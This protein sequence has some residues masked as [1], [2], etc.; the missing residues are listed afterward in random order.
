MIANPPFSLKEWGARFGR[1]TGPGRVRSPARELRRLRL[2]SAHGRVDGRAHR[3]DG[4]CCRKGAV[5]KSAEGR[6]RQALLEED[7]IEA[8]IGLAPNVFYGTGLAPRRGDPPPLSRPSARRRSGDRRL[9]PLPQGRAQNFLELEHAGRSSAWA[10]AFEDVETAPRSSVSTR[11]SPRTG[12]STSPAT[13]C[14]RSATRSAARR[15]SPPSQALAEA[16]RRGPAARGADRG[17]LGLLSKAAKHLSQQELESY[18]RGQPAPRADRRWRLQAVRLPAALLQAAVGRGTRS[19]APRSTRPAT[20]PMRGR[21]PTTASPSPT[22]RT[23][24]TSA[25]RRATWAARCST[26]SV[27]SRRPTRAALRRLRQRGVDGQGTAPR[28]DAE[29]P[30]RALL[31][32]FAEPERRPGGRARQ[33]LRVPDQAV[34]RRQRPHGAGVLHQPHSSI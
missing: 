3:P 33:R 19:T 12:R 9:E 21:P 4:E 25:A 28:R 6:I 23:G 11:S 26:P 34:R 8:V 17:R 32:P 14:R 20:P 13:C 18:L 16:R 22:A 7:L 15:R 30:D 10:Q 29:E 31:A 2:G 24:R 5:P 1:P 27:R